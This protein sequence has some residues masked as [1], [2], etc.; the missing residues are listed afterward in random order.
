MILLDD[1]EREL[2]RQAALNALNCVQTFNS[3]ESRKAAAFAA[4]VADN[5]VNSYR[6][7]NKQDE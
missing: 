6:K 5:I 1:T 3:D 7:R 2:W 4:L